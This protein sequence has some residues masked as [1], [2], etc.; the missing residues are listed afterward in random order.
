MLANTSIL[1]HN[2]F[3]FVLGIIK[4]HSLSNLEAYNTVLLALITLL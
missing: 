4:I 3:V 2:Y 1:S